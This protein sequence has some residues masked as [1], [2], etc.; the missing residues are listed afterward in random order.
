M[1]SNQALAILAVA[2]TISSSTLLTGFCSEAPEGFFPLFNGQDLSGWTGDT[3][4]YTV[5]NGVLICNNGRHIFTEMEYSNFILR[6]EFKLTPGANSGLG[7]RTPIGE[8][9]PAYTGMELQILDD[10]AEKYKDLKDYQFHGSIYGMVPAKRGALKPVGEWNAQEVVADGDRIKVTLNGSVIVDASLKE[11]A[12]RGSLDG[13][14]HSGLLREKGHIALLGHG[15]TL[16]F[17]NLYLKEL[18]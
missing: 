13:N 5:E 6:F 1:R 18:D 17:R 16:E 15:D 10:T 14:P 8:G 9:D 3:A 4:N 2:V 7:I 12:A 11:A